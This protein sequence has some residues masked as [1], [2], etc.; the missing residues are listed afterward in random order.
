MLTLRTEYL[1]IYCMK[2]GIQFQE[3][4]DV[5]VSDRVS[6]R[7]L[8]ENWYTISRHF[9]VD[10]SKTVYLFGDVLITTGELNP[11]PEIVSKTRFF[12]LLASATPDS[13]PDIEN[14]GHFS[15]Q[16]FVSLI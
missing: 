8:H 11:V 14:R 13:N 2:V 12:F 6:A 4:F 16:P 9:Y 1:H 10:V 7:L 5:D 3:H 15:V